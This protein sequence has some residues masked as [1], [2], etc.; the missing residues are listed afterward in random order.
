MKSDSVL[1][2]H[3][4]IIVL[5]LVFSCLAMCFAYKGVAHAFSETAVP[6]GLSGDEAMLMRLSGPFAPLLSVSGSPFVALTI[7]SGTGSLLNAGKINSAHIPFAEALVQ[8]PISQTFVFVCLLIV[9]IVKYLLSLSV[10]TKIFS[11]ATLTKFENLV[12]AVVVVGGAFLL[13]PAAPAYAAEIAETGLAGGNIVTYTL[14]GIIAFFMAVLAYAMFFVMKTMI[15]ALDI[16]ASIFSPIPGTTAVFA[17]IKFIIVGLYTWCALAHPFFASIIGAVCLLLAIIVFRAARRLELYYRKIYLIPFSRALLRR[18]LVMPLL[19]KKLPYG[20]A[21]EFPDVEICLEG[22]FMNR[23][24]ALC[25]RERC[26]FVR[27]GGVN[28][29]FKKRL[30]GK[31]VK[32]AI[33]DV[34][35]IERTFRLIRIFTD[36]EAR[37]DSRRV[38]LVLR[39]EY[40]K[41]IAALIERAGLLDYNGL[42]EERKRQKTEE[43]ALKAQ[44]AKGKAL[45]AIKSLL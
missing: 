36:E 45:N 37:A 9:S 30:F 20:L 8:L 25:K 31:V 11:D 5:L 34:A 43:K 29:I 14:S 28:Y 38:F 24:S 39:R 42:L 15:A 2:G 18:D 17:N 12:G 3:R 26:Y 13:S 16:L 4:R 19:P 6:S 32:L 33:P 35:Y 27:S 23:V 21:K 10:A 44:Q 41:N 40:G 22:F 7:L 1:S